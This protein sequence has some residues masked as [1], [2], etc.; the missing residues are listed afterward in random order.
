MTDLTGLLPDG[1]RLGDPSPL[2]GSTRS[3]VTRHEVVRGP[4]AWGSSVVVKR[5]LP[6]PEGRSAAMGWRREM[7]GLR[8]LRGTPE[9][10]LADE[11]AQV[12]VMED[13]GAGATLADALLGADPGAAWGHTV[14]WAGTLGG[15]LAAGPESLARARDD[16]GSALLAED[17]RWQEDYPRRGVEHL[18]DVAGLR[19]GRAA[20]AQ[21]LDVVDELRHDTDRHVLGPGDACPDNAVLTPSGVRL[22]DVEGAGVR[23]VAYEAAYA[24]EPFSTCW[25]VFTP[26]GGLTE[27]TL[28]A[29][30]REAER[31]LPGLAAD[32]RWP[33]QVRAAVALWVLSGT[34]WLLDGA[35][36]DRTMAPEGRTGP[37]FRALLLH[38]WGWVAR[39][40]AEELPDVAA[41]C[42]EATV[43]ARRSWASARGRLELPGY[44]AFGV[45]R[46]QRDPAN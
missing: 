12:L 11:E 13:L 24:A 18:V 10:L 15:S 35:V 25:C 22:L 38:R 41:L 2:G 16:L 8:H 30:T 37:A 39:A 23:H 34:L 21:A 28:T 4:A 42:E 46:S 32:P 31:S 19:S 33:R 7:V 44:P 40:C 5:F 27:A 17:R 1:V 9:L 26:P 6:Q 20:V 3:E 36:A 29:F 45:A 14:A 43:W